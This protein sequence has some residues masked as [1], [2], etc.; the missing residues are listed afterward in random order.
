M[1]LSL[2]RF[3]ITSQANARKLEKAWIKYQRE[4]GLDLHGAARTANAPPPC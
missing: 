4:N 1:I 2:G 3:G